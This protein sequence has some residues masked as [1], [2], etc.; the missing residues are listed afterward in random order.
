MVDLCEKKISEHSSKSEKRLVTSSITLLFFNNFGRFLIIPFQKIAST[1]EF[2]TWIGCFDLFTKFELGNVFRL[3][4]ASLLTMIE[5]M[6]LYSIS[7]TSLGNC[8]SFPK[9]FLKLPIKIIF[10]K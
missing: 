6:V 2:L 10:S 9:K 1:K 3:K 8:R 7:G 4:P 5:N